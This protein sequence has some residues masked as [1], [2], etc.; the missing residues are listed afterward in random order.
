LRFAAE[1][2]GIAVLVTH[3]GIGQASRLAEKPHSAAV[4]PTQQFGEVVDNLALQLFPVVQPGS[5]DVMGVEA[6]SERSDQ[7][8]LGPHRHASST[9]IPRILG[10]F[11]VM[12]DD[13]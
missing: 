7:P 11:G 12:Q 4:E 8:Q 2:E 1:D 10:N 3:A 6:K 9:D 5:A 13:V